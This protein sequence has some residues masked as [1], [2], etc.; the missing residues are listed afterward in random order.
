MRRWGKL[1]TRKPVAAA[2]VVLVMLLA[3]LS[4]L[5]ARKVDQD[6][7]L[8]EFL[9]KSNPTVAAFYDINRRFGGLDVGIVG[10]EVDNPFDGA[11]LGKLRKLAKQLN[12]EPT[13]AFALTLANV[14]DFAPDPEQGGIRTDYLVNPLPKTDAEQQALRAKVMGREQIVGNLVSADGRAVNLYCFFGHDA[15]PRTTAALVR[16]AVEAA[17]PEHRKYWG[18]APFISGYIYNITQRDMSRLIPWAVLVIVVIVMVSFRDVVGTAL[19][20]VSTGIGILMARGLMGAMGV[21]ANLVLSSMPVILFAVG[22][23][24]AIHVLV[25]YYALAAVQ[26]AEAALVATLEQIGPTV[27]AAGLTTVAGLMSFLVMDIRPM[28]HFGLFTGLGILATLLLSLS[29]VPAVVSLTGLRAKSLGRS[30]FTNGLMALVAFAQRHRRYLT[31]GLVLVAAAGG[32]MAGRVQARME[33]AAFFAS[34]SPPAE[35]EAFLAKN[36]GGSQFIQIWARGDFTEPTVLRELQRVAD[37]IAVLPHVSSV[38]HVGS[39]LAVVNEA[40]VGERRLPPEAAQ[41][42]V[43]YR[44]LAGRASVRQ[45]VTDDHREALVQVKIDTDRHDEI[46]ALLSEVNRVVKHEALLSFAVR[47]RDGEDDGWLR[48]LVL[49]RIAA[50]ARAMSLPIDAAAQQNLRKA[51]GETASAD[52]KAVERRLVQFLGSDES[53]LEDGNRRHAA[54]IAQALVVL[55]AGADDDAVVQALAKTLE[56]EPDDELVDDLSISVATPLEEIWRQ[57]RSAARA[58]KI[59]A[60]AGIER[61][62]GARG[63]QLELGIANALLDLS[64]PQ[65]IAPSDGADAQKLALD[66]NGVPVLYR[67]LSRSV[68]ANQFKSLGLA[69]ALVLVIMIGLFRSFTAGMLAAAPT[70]VTLL[71]VYG[72]MGVL[73]MNLDIGTSMLASIII[74]AGV[75]YAV[76]LLAAWRAGGDEQLSDAAQR[77][78]EA[79]GPAIW[80]NALMVGAGF[81]VLTLGEAKPLKNVGGL[82]ATAMIAAALAT[83]VALPVLARRRSYVAGRSE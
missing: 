41:V 39:I 17:F 49:A 58:R 80:T 55:G 70:V 22:S 47:K 25:R 73:G 18:G 29:F 54:P 21:D 33:N 42:K 4:W 62:E 45:L 68:T 36:F 66:V 24:Y 8:L 19:A 82:T 12:A 53:M 6:D 50:H 1:L 11:F 26:D 30:M 61:P 83:F 67:G 63:E 27:L 13:I 72:L 51:L 16:G 23:A 52:R 59:M 71:V 44:F 14:D 46:D 64:S 57:E 31:V 75:D 40:M 38:L 81:F 65:V 35:A 79:A 76:H 5:G 28:R 77:A 15:D 43:L 32:T 2:V 10:L 48:E 60:A 3:G 9:P 56:R 69:L 74:G 20:L 7:D 34:D 78:A 37:R